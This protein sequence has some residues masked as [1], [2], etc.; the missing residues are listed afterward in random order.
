MN[1]TILAVMIISNYSIEP[2]LYN[3][4]YNHEQSKVILIS[5]DH[6]N[7]P[8]NI[9]IC[10]Y[11]DLPPIEYFSYLFNTSGVATIEATEAAASVKI[12]NHRLSKPEFWHP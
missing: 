4:V 6:D 2:S 11:I 7:I 1:V 3:H 5:T 12:L 8:I 9:S 10:N